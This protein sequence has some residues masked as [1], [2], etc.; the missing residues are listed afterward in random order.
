M[1]WH[2]LSTFVNLEKGSWIG[3][4]GSFLFVSIPLVNHLPGLVPQ[5]FLIELLLDVSCLNATS[6]HSLQLSFTNSFRL[7]FLHFGRLI[8]AWLMFSQSP[9]T[10]LISLEAPMKEGLPHAPLKTF[11]LAPRGERENGFH[12]PTVRKGYDYQ[13]SKKSSL[14]ICFQIVLSYICVLNICGGFF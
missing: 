11:A 7:R 8:V 5:S 14:Y 1:I 6:W 10:S 9:G 3:I 4:T 2:A 12:N 13:E